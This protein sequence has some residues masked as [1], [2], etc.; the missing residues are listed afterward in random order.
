MMAT[1]NPATTPVCANQKEKTAK[2]DLK[3]RVEVKEEDQERELKG[4]KVQ[5]K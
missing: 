5:R 1:S 2:K 3:K 4:R